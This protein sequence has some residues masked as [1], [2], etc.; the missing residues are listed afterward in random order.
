MEHFNFD[1]FLKGPVMTL[2]GLL[3][4]SHAY[5]GWYMDALTNWQAGGAAM[6]GLALMFL[7]D[8]FP[9]LLKEFAKS[10]IDKFKGGPQK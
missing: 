8:E 7:K 9:S 2:A 6:A 4:M 5:Y 3:I 10:L 1:N